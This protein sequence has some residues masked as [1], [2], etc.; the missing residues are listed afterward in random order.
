MSRQI[1]NISAAVIAVVICINGLCAAEQPVRKFSVKDYGA[2]SNSKADAGPGI[3]QAI[4]EAV[5]SG[6]RAEVLLEE[7]RYL[8]KPMAGST[9]CISIGGV[10]GLTIKG[11]PGKTEL[12]IAD[13]AGEGIIISD[14]R[15]L[16]LK[17]LM[18]DYDPLPFTQGR[19]VSVDPDNAAFDLNIDS[20]YPLLSEP[21]FN[22]SSKFG[23]VIDAHKRQLKAG[24]SDHMFAS[25]W[26]HITNRIWRI[27]LE[28]SQRSKIN[29][30]A[31]GD[32]YV[33]MARTGWATIAFTGS[34]N[35]RLENVSI[36]ASASLSCALIR[37]EG[38]IT[39]NNFAVRYKPGTDRLLSSDADGVHCQQNRVGPTIENCYFE[40]MA[41]DS[42]NIYTPP[43]VVKSV[44]SPT[45]LIVS[46]GSDMR[47]GDLLQVFD[48]RSANVRSEVKALAVKT[49]GDTYNLTLEKSVDGIQAGKD[50]READTIYNLSACGA[51]YV[52]CNNTMRNHRRHGI[53]LRA[54]NGIVEGNTIDDVAGLG[55]VLTNEPGWPEGP[56]PW[57]VVIRNNTINGCGYGAGYGDSSRGASI[58]VQGIGLN[59]QLGEK[60]PI[61]DITISGNRFTNTPGGAIFVGGARG[62][63]ISGN[64]ANASVTGRNYRE[65]ASITLD[66]CED[67][68]LDKNTVNDLRTQTTSAVLIMPS[69]APGKA[70]VSVRSLKSHLN[71]GSITV[72]DERRP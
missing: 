42:V 41:D 66:N 34:S 52:I 61:H 47:P 13:P 20:G 11:K 28:E 16:T 40:G 36:Y 3:R 38:K 26:T 9:R 33:Q 30:V 27:T 48:P 63:R 69:N 25:G 60:R 70:G 12:V 50:F 7:G 35:C 56:I 43:C 23:I 62:V 15:N 24:V 54:G 46:Q 10:T 58:L 45:E 67:V 8:I 71:S 72:I 53:L 4:S 5:K 51:G 1:F 49:E 29:G 2:V 22:L 19:I 37:N 14:C 44:I 55:I 39:L 17:D 6:G 65:C 18:I 31:V 68:V 32:R 21:Y 64:T 59:G 57:D